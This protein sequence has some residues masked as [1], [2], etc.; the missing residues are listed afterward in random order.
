MV[1]WHLANL[2]NRGLLCKLNQHCCQITQMSMLIF[3]CKHFMV[4][5]LTFVS[6]RTKSEQEICD[7]NNR[8]KVVTDKCNTTLEIGLVYFN[9]LFSLGHFRYTYTSSLIFLNHWKAMSH[10]IASIQCYHR[11]LLNCHGIYTVLSECC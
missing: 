10:Q 11:M 5:I 3:R 4:R 6:V 2:N 8:T 9:L 7:Q 1:R